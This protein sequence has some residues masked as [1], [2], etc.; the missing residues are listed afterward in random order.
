MAH[1]L[2]IFCATGKS[3]RVDDQE[4]RKM[5]PTTVTFE[6]V[7]HLAVTIQL[8]EI[9]AASPFSQI[10]PPESDISCAA[11]LAVVPHW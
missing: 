10:F 9:R 4:I 2:L 8:T 5:R 7:T 11:R 3:F 1:N 6:T